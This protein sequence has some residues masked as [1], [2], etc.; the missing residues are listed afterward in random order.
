MACGKSTVSKILKEDAGLKIVNCRRISRDLVQPGQSAF[1]ALVEE[2]GDAM[3]D[4]QAGRINR[5]ALFG[6]FFR[7]R[8][9]RASLIRMMK[10]SMVFGIIRD[11]VTH[12]KNRE[13]VVVL[14]APVLFESKFLNLFCDPI[15]VVSA[16]REVQIKRIVYRDHIT[17]EEASEKINGEMSLYEKIKGADIVITN[18]GTEDELR[19]QVLSVIAKEGFFEPSNFLSTALNALATPF[20]SKV[21]FEISVGKNED[22]SSKI[23]FAFRENDSEV[24]NDS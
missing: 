22:G 24:L 10:E 4:H 21:G 15:M 19:E 16:T 13:R 2:F 12:I 6:Q 3:I 20:I 1:N 9:Q 14:D 5:K 17:E 7:S 8:E 18:D 11:L 23:L